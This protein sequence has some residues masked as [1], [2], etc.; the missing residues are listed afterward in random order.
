MEQCKNA[1]Q[2]FVSELSILENDVW[3]GPGCTLT[4]SMYPNSPRAKQNLKGV[5][6]SEGAILGADT[7]VYQVK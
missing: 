6:I 2:R 5:H 7:I 4:N 3:L 1:F